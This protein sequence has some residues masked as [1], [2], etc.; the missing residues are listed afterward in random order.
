MTK[1]RKTRF[2]ELSDCTI[3]P[4]ECHTNRNVDITGFC[5]SG[6][7]FHI[8][9]ICVHK[10]EEPVLSGTHGMCNVFF[11][12]CN[13]RCIYCQ[14][15]QISRNRGPILGQEMSLSEIVKQI[16]EIMEGGISIVGFVSPSHVIPQMRA[17]IEAIRADGLNPTFVMNTNAYDKVETIASLADMIDVYLPDLKYMDSDLAARYSATPDYPGVATAAIAEMYHQKGAQIELDNEGLIR[18]GLIVRHLVLPETVENS[19]K[20]LRFIAKSLSPKVHLSVMSQY[21]PTEAVRNH[22]QLGRPLREEEYDEVLDEMD[23]L[24]LDNGWIQ[25]ME[26]NVEYVPDFSRPSPFEEL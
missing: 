5:G 13:M 25:E 24:G 26:S 20:C 15:A 7:D 12:R 1:G 9:S 21:H 8:G 2:P 10:G 16:E 19:K 14:N 3:C 22:P 18:S 4:R 6:A 11:T 17:I 23:R